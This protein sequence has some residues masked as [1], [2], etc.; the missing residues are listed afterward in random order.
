[1]SNA[2][3]SLGDALSD[4]KAQAFIHAGAMAAP[5]VAKTEPKIAEKT[6]SESP[7]NEPDTGRGGDESEIDAAAPAR[8]RKRREAPIR[9]IEPVSTD[10]LVPLTTRVRRS[11]A[12][13]IERAYM[14]HR[15][16][17]LTPSTKQE[18]VEA[19]LQ[20]WLAANGFLTE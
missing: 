17:K 12:D 5:A 1:M 9:Q 13:G 18:I 15:L 19:A 3:R 8:R 20:E 4:P 6:L 7:A 2:R 14:E 16:R 10:L 11:I